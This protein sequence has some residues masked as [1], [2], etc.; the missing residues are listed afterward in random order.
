MKTE[1][2]G[3]GFKIQLSQWDVT[4]LNAKNFSLVLPVQFEFEVASDVLIF[5]FKSINA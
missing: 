1:I 3:Y 5:S 4:Y 2:N